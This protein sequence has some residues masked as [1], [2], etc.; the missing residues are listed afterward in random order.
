MAYFR[1]RIGRRLLFAAAITLAG[2]AGW[3]VGLPAGIAP[4]S[5]PGIS[6]AETNAVLERLQPPKRV[7]PLIAIIGLNNATETT[8][9]LMPYGILRQADVAD[10]ALVSVQGGPVKLYP[11]LS[12]QSDL[13][14][15]EFDTQ[16]PDG[17]DYV[18]VPAMGPH[19]ELG[20]ELSPG[21]DEVTLAVVADAWS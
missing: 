17:A 16:Y 13:S 3:V 4:V 8:D 10:V 12:V 11:A 20:I 2:F 9:Y 15:A 7:R 21:V 1:Y 14:I 19:E 5:P 18:I 6:E